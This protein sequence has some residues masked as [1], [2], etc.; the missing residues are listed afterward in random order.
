MVAFVL[1]A[2][3]YINAQ[4]TISPTMDTFIQSNVSTSSF[5]TSDHFEMRNGGAMRISF[6]DIPVNTISSFS[7]VTSAML[8]VYLWVT[9]AAAES[10]EVYQV[11]TQGTGTAAIDNNATWGTATYTLGSTLA[12]ITL[13]IGDAVGTGYSFNLTNFIK[14]LSP[15]TQKV[16][17]CFKVPTGGAPSAEDFCSIDHATAAWRPALVYN[18]TS[19]VVSVTGVTVS[20]S[21]ASVGIGAT[22]NLTATFA[23]SNATNQNVNWTSSNNA[24]ATVSASGVVTGV[25]VGSADITATTVDGSFTSKSTITVVNIPVTGVTVSPNPATVVAGAYIPLAATI[26][27]ANATNKTVTWSSSNNAVARVSASGVV[28]GMS[29]G[30]ANITATSQ[31]G[32]FTSSSSITVSQAATNYALNPGFE[33]NTAPS[34]TATN[35]FT[36]TGSSNNYIINSGVVAGNIGLGDA[37][38]GTPHSGTN[39][40]SIA[41][42]A[43][44]PTTFDVLNK[45]DL[46][47]LPNGT[48]TLKA[49]FRGTGGGGYFNVGA[50]Y[51]GFPSPMTQWTQ[52]T[53]NNVSVTNGTATINIQYSSTTGTQLDVDDIQFTLNQFV[54]VTGVNA[55]SPASKTLSLNETTTLTTTTIPSN[56]SNSTINWSS[57]NTAVATVS[58]TGIVT[59]VSAGTATITATTAEGGFTS[60]SAITVANNYVLNPSFEKD[61]AAVVKAADWSEWSGTPAYTDNSNVITG[62]VGLGD[63]VGGAPHSGTYYVEVAPTVANPINYGVLN[64]QSIA[65]IPNDTYVLT[66]WFRGNGGSGYLNI[67]VAYNNFNFANLSQWTQLTI[68]D[69]VISTGSCQIQVNYTADNGQ[70]LDIDDIQ[71]TPKSVF[72]STALIAKNTNISISPTVIANNI[73]NISNSV[74]GNYEVSISNINGQTMYTNKLN[75]G[76]VSINTS[77]LKTGMYLV[78]VSNGIENCV[79]KVIIP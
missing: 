50:T 65:N 56:A 48:Y 25:S 33:L 45:Q 70:K 35:W 43:T 11:L 62:I 72:T 18:V 22:T 10:I 78:R 74:K 32:S 5:G 47:G 20:P 57:S 54:L 39:Y 52:S 37:V 58:A 9:P 55:V 60:T 29:V 12:S 3:S 40:L 41:P 71:L 38:G 44:W 23:P 30:T 68:N 64:F 14:G 1:M 34:A 63:A 75:S 69:V 67:G 36:W 27:P 13:K 53:I 21:S 79:Q 19:S 73:L 77:F 59:A 2:V 31:D 66:G 17:L 4:T 42:T 76:N 16:T 61:N 24:V 26:A 6:M 49:W 8:N 15:G 46:S 51:I 28:S 7:S